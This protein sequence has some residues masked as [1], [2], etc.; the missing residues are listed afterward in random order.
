[1]ENKN[2]LINVH[3]LVD[4][5]TNS[6]TE[7][8]IVDANK[9]QETM[10]ELF[11][12]LLNCTEIDFETEIF[13]YDESDYKNDYVLPEE[14]ENN[15]ENLYF[16]NASHHNELL[17]QIIDKYFNPIELEYKEDYS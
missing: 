16:I 6:S 8:F 13:K 10:K 14:Y 3:S 12:F 15:T 17:M 7:L 11:N 2:I 1:M 4:V 9:V 5:I